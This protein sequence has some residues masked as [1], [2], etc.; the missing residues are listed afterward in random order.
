[1]KKTIFVI[2]SIALLAAGTFATEALAGPES[3]CKACHTF[4]QGGKHKTG[5]N[6]FG[7][8][9]RQAGGTDFK[10][11]GKSLKNAN[12]VWDEE[13]LKAWVCDSKKAIKDLTGDEHAKTRMGKQ[14]KCGDDA[15]AVVAFLKT[16]K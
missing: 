11:Y 5:P 16:L 14:K 1:M 8:M 6:L 9:G 10:K 7:I 13:N 3:R 15:E 12:W 4:D 2:S